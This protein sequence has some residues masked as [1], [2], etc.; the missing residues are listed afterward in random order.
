[1][2]D[3]YLIFVVILF[4]LAI[5]DLVV[6]VSN[7][8]VNFLN[9]AIGSRVA[10]KRLIMIV[11]SLGVFVGA[12][13]SDGMM[14]VARKGIFVPNE[15]FFSE[16][17]VIF[18][19]VMITDIL[20]LDFFNSVGLPTSTTVSIV[21]ELLGAAVA[22][23]LL[24]MA[25]NSEGIDALSNYI[26]WSTAGK[27]ISGI[28]LAVFVAFLVGLLVQYLSRLLL[29][30]Q[31]Q[32]RMKWVG[33]IWAGFAFTALTF[34]LLIKGL[35]HASFITAETSDWVKDNTMMLVGVSFVVLTLVMYGLQWL[36]VNI[37]RVVVLFGTFALAMAFAGNDLVNFIGVPI[38]GLESFTQWQAS[39][40]AADQFTM[41]GL[42]GKVRTSSW[43]LLGAGAVMIITLW[44]SKKAQSVTATTVDLSRQDEGDERFQT[45]IV[46]R[47]LV[48]FGLLVGRG[49]K[50][51]VP[52][53]TLDKMNRNFDQPEYVAAP[54]EPTTA[55]AF[56]L[57]RAS[58][59]LVVASMLIAYGTSQKLPLSTT[60]VSFMVVMGASLADRAWGRDSAVYRISGVVSVITGWLGTAAIAFTAAA[61]FAVCIYYGGLAVVIGLV[62]LAVVLLIRSSIIVARKER[63]KEADIEYA[64]ESKTKSISEVEAELRQQVA[65]TL[66]AVHEAFGSAVEGLV[67]EDTDR[68]KKAKKSMKSLRKANEKLRLRLFTNIQSMSEGYDS[69]SK[70]YI[71]VYDL[72]RDLVQSTTVIVKGAISHVENKHNPISKTQIAYLREVCDQLGNYLNSV[73]AAINSGTVKAKEV[74]VARKEMQALLDG[75][76]S[77]QVKGIRNKDY[78]SRNSF[79][80]FNIILE[81]WDLVWITYRFARI[82]ETESSHSHLVEPTDGGE[83]F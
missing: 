61:I 64:D 77:D 27:I 46:A 20:L 44:F 45:N 58:V 13:F 18:L 73:G 23:S 1:M 63:E 55:P 83:E 54:G 16:I 42:A 12:T 52:Q 38:A 31:Y 35:K 48:N 59:N 65:D 6:G 19:A 15:F 3:P 66:T 74:A 17:M 60:Y 30:F 7:D 53:A 21:F 56:D 69:G 68:L 72:E 62:V 41:E 24:K 22:V 25:H 34:F 29:S 14:E 43:L 67:E 75:G 10:P 71:S 76:V 26:N 50:A 82:L 37:L 36:K 4:A 51:I 11:A 40:L 78:G 5:T 81:A 79:L 57:V 80:Y 47:G 49:F 32:K 2:A 39:G 70:L 28:F 33:G 8:A 9:S